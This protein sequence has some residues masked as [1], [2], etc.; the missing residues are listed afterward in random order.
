LDPS[1][2]VTAVACP[3]FVPFAE[4][5]LLSGNAVLEVARKITLPRLRNPGGYGDIR[6]HALSFTETGYKEGF[7]G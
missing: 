6:V 1:I 5:G 3:L 4:E 7:R 2:K